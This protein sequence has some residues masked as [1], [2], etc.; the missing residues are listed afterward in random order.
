MREK[1]LLYLTDKDVSLYK[2]VDKKIGPL[3]LDFKE[4][5]REI[6]TLLAQHPKSS[7]SLCIDRGHQ[8]VQEE[9][10]PFLFPWDKLRFLVHK[11]AG[12]ITDRGSVG[13]HFFKQEK[14][15]FLDGLT[16]P[17]MI[18]SPFGDHG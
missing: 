7:L 15:H 5:H 6:Y 10:L 1:F 16:S 4:S 3:A 9:K 18:L 2:G 13:F 14:E 11:K 8:D 17:R 12:W